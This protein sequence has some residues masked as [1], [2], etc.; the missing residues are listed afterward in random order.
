MTK[1]EYKIDPEKKEVRLK[2]SGYKGICRELSFINLTGK[3]VIE[4][5][6]NYSY[7]DFIENSEKTDVID[8]SMFIFP[9]DINTTAKCSDD[10]IFDEK[11]GM[12]I[13][14]VKADLKY[15][16]MMYNRYVYIDYVLGK[17][18]LAIAKLEK[19]HLEK[20]ERLER[21]LDQYVK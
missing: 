9:N 10:D 1:R 4:L 6:L 20:I 16:N 5:I 8:N 2:K 15:H 11:T 18:K 7:L 13:C 3:N 14:D 12:R 17:L 21:D 19:K